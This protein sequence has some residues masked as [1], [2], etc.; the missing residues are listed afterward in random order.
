[1]IGDSTMKPVRMAMRLVVCVGLIGSSWAL[2][3][4]WPQWRGPN[5]DGV[6]QETGLLKEWPKEGPTMLWQVKD[7]GSGYSTPSVVGGRLYVIANTGLQDEFAKALE[8][9]GGKVIW[10]TRIGKVGKPNQQ[11][12]YAAARSTPTV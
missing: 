12:N 1:M 5:R 7:L 11:P 4:D 2:A 8:V 10:S 9:K 3:A 6:S